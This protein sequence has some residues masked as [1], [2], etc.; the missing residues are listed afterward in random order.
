MTCST[1]E[2]AVCCASDSRSSLSRRVLDGDDGLGG[3]VREQGN[4]LVRE[5][6]HLLAINTDSANYRV[7]LEHWHNQHR[8]RA[9]KF[10]DGCV[11]VLCREIGDFHG[12]LGLD[13][14]TNRGLSDG[15]NR[16]ESM[17]LQELRRRSMDTNAAKIV[18]LDKNQDAKFGLA[19]AHCLL[20][21]G[22][23]YGL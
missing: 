20:Q 12:A 5:R 22:L 6:L 21:H 16:V 9:G 1:S 3:E 23:E 7:L 8:S 13:D 18:P 14:P 15:Y 19:H 4:L 17:L 11:A 10:N 2:V